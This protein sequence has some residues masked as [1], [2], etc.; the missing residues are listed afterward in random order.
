M[1]GL[2]PWGAVATTAAGAVATHM[3][4]TK[5]DE[6]SS[7]FSATAKRLEDLSLR[8]HGDV[9]LG[10]KEWTNFVRNCEEAIAAENPKWNVVK[11]EE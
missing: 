10:S 1:S 2:A 7:Q 8:L 6:R 5:L 11:S 9:K 3:H 4:A